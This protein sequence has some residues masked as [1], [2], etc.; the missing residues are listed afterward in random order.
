MSKKSRW[1]KQ[2]WWGADVDND[3]ADTSATENSVGSVVH[4]ESETPSHTNVHKNH[5]T[6]GGFLGYYFTHY[7]RFIIIPMI[8]LVL[9][10]A[11]ITYQVSTTG[12]FMN[13]GVSLKGGV[14]ITISD[15]KASSIDS[16]NLQTRLSSAFSQYDISVNSIG[17]SGDDATLVIEA[18]VPQNDK[19]IM[20]FV[21]V[22]EKESGISED[23][24]TTEVMGSSL[25]SSFFKETITAIIV[26]FV[27][28]AIVVLVY[29]RSFY[30]S[31]AVIAAA[32]ADMIMTL[33][34]VN[35]LGI[36]VSTAGIAAFLMLIGYS[37]DTDMLLTSRV[38]KV[39]LGTV[40]EK[41]VSAMK[42]GLLMTLTTIAAVT[43]A[44]LVSTSEVIRQ[45]MS[46]LL[47]GLVFDIFNTWITN[48]ILLKIY[49]HK[50]GHN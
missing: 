49:M 28:M 19:D 46:I 5:S 42:T 45:I 39:K 7:K 29:F 47:I 12:D 48:V 23:K 21:S 31:M 15:V 36:K 25:G 17:L 37:V 41:I 20:E 4:V 8:I 43:V 50:K 13:K 38:L 2:K 6:Y 32:G 44:L 34:V 27:L 1:K 10:I 30:P 33:A 18:D 3:T 16:E 14:T 35:F 22:L 11:Q 26:A 40:D 9:A 24:F